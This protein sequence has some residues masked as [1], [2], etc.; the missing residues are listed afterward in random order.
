MT[1]DDAFVI[2]TSPG[3][4]FNV[5]TTRELIG[6]EQILSD[7]PVAM[8]R[9]APHDMTEGDVAKAFKNLSRDEQKDSLEPHEGSRSFQVQT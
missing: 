8:I 9:K 5:F 3:K 4:G 6:G 1:T 2:K 7:R